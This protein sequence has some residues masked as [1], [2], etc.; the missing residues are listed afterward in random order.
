MM[1]RETI[2][3]AGDLSFR[4]L[5]LFESVGRLSSVRRGSE[6]CNLSQ[7]AVTQ[8]LSKLEQQVGVTLLERRSSGSYLTEAG[9]VFHV[10]VQRLFGQMAQAMV[11]LGAASGEIAAAAVV[12]RIS[13][14]QVRSLIAIV[15][16]GSF[17]AASRTLGLT[18]ASLQRSARDLEG[19]LRKS[20]Y[21]RAAAGVMVSPE[22]VELGRKF[23]LAIQEVE[24]GMR[25]ISALNGSVDSQIVIGALPFGGSLLLASALDGFV[26]AHPQTKVRIVSEGAHE[27]LKR[28]RGGDVDL[29][30]GIVQG[31]PV[32]GLNNERLATTPFDIVGRSGHPLASKKT[33][34]LDDL[35]ACEWILAGDGSV[36]RHCFDNLFDGRDLP[37]API[38]TSSLPITQGL[39]ASS[40]RLTLMTS[41]EIAGAGSSLTVIPYGPL[42]PRPAIGITTRS[43]WLPTRQHKDFV[44]LL[45][46]AVTGWHDGFEP[47]AMM[48]A[49]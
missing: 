5:K 46:E 9:K 23:K 43:D 14:S 20:I 31:H 7:P 18:Q 29:L 27:M 34:S 42:D 41:Y 11:D 19:N 26:A 16:T 32:P 39:L 37:Y 1:D 3:Q 22:G 25:E 30:V 13:R 33:T 8:A 15:E 36:R 45:R 21:H 38:T 4:Q 49:G 17:V 35:G 2:A 10:R 47:A 24:W 48:L 6:E 44:A 12:N 28:L 40:D